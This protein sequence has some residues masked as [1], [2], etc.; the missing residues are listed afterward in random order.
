MIEN[1]DIKIMNNKVSNKLENNF[2]SNIN[3][4]N[5]LNSKEN[6]KCDVGEIHG[7][8]IK[9]NKNFLISKIDKK[10]LKI[11][12]N[13]N[14]ND[15]LNEK[16]KI[17]KFSNLRNLNIKDNIQSNNYAI[18]IISTSNRENS[19]KNE[20]NNIFGQISHDMS[21]GIFEK[22]ENEIKKTFEFKTK[23]LKEDCETNYNSEVNNCFKDNNFFMFQHDL[24]TNKFDNFFNEKNNYAF[25]N[26]VRNQ[27]NTN[28]NILK[29]RKRDSFKLDSFNINILNKNLTNDNR[30]LERGSFSTQKS[31]SLITQNKNLLECSFE[32]NSNISNINI[33]N[34]SHINQIVNKNF[35]REK[36]SII[37]ELKNIEQIHFNFVLIS[38]ASK[39][40]MKI[41]ETINDTQENI[42]NTVD[43]INEIDIY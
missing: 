9:L 3:S 7:Q 35:I 28:R 32:S 16:D 2:N 15:E 39:K 31:I 42:M 27:K 17:I 43:E 22:S 36:Q 37:N 5:N 33:N 12:T 14:L 4:N 25:E 26:N 8:N 21:T 23:D 1:T 40:I 18:N 24:E 13:I 41:E 38:Q 34:I 11:Y 19:K 6:E 10:H 30:N 29:N 20:S